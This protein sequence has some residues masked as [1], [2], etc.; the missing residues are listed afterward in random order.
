MLSIERMVMRER[1]VCKT[2]RDRTLL[3]Y[4]AIRVL[5]FCRV[6]SPPTGG[7]GG[8]LRINNH[9]I[10]LPNLIM[11]TALSTGAPHATFPIPTDTPLIL[12]VIVLLVYPRWKHTRSYLVH[13]DSR[14]ETGVSHGRLAIEPSRIRFT[15]Y[16]FVSRYSS[17]FSPDS[18]MSY[19]LPL[20]TRCNVFA[21]FIVFYFIM[22]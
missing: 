11:I 8:I 9:C 5:G 12:K 18:I 10:L 15:Q 17:V 7:V 13:R 2:A 19:H 3:Q 4:S 21:C 1:A 6:I 16:C 22:F 20:R 14:L